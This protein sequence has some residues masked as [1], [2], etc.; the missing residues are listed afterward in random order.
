[1]ASLLWRKDNKEEFLCGTIPFNKQLIAVV[2]WMWNKTA[3]CCTIIVYFLLNDQKKKKKHTNLNEEKKFKF[4]RQPKCMQVDSGEQNLGD[5]SI[6]R[7]VPNKTDSCVND[8]LS[9]M[10]YVIRYGRHL[11]W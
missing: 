9:E 3:N 4:L 10:L 1:M 5:I 2:S 8:K 11:M 6:I 7:L